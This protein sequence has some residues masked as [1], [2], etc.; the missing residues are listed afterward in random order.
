MPWQKKMRPDKAPEKHSTMG[1]IEKLDL[2]SFE[3]KKLLYKKLQLGMS[4]SSE[5]GSECR[6]WIG[7]KSIRLYVGGET[8]LTV[9]PKAL[10]NFFATGSRTLPSLNTCGNTECLAPNHINAIAPTSSIVSDA[11]SIKKAMGLLKKTNGCLHISNK[12]ISMRGGKEISATKVLKLLSM[13]EPANSQKFSELDGC[14]DSECWH[15]G[16]RFERNRRL[17]GKKTRG[18]LLNP[19]IESANTA[20]KGVEVDDIFGKC[21]L[22]SDYRLMKVLERNRSVFAPRLVWNGRSKLKDNHRIAL[23]DFVQFCISIRYFG[24][25]LRL[26]TENSLNLNHLGERGLICKN[27]ADCA[28]PNHRTHSYL[29]AREMSSGRSRINVGCLKI[30]QIDFADNVAHPIHAVFIKKDFFRK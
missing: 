21:F 22:P 10:A 28:N 26:S 24:E 18:M 23:A 9:K 30:W 6:F 12:R 13:Y 1:R 16:H 4:S 5:K 3:E 19:I 8:K 15:P 20:L 27:N 17:D 11:D 29:Q 14:T 2:L 7:P 25:G